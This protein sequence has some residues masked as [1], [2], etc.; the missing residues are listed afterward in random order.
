MFLKP[1]WHLPNQKAPSLVFMCRTGKAITGLTG[2]F[3]KFFESDAV[4]CSVVSFLFE[5]FSFGK[6]DWQTDIDL[7]CPLFDNEK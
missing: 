3:R 7:C 4:G 6:A 1:E 5:V 2:P